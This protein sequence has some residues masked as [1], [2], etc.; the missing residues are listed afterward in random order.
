MAER[1]LPPLS[2]DDLILSDFDGT[3]S[4]I[5]TGM[6]VFD[7]LELEEAWAV[8]RI[9]QAGEID[10]MEC[11]RLQWNM[12]RLNPEEMM[13]LIDK[14]GLDPNFP[15]LLAL[16]AERQAGL[17]ILSDGLD[18]YVDHYLQRWG[19][20]TSADDADVRYHGTICRYANHAEL[21]AEGVQ[22]D[23]PYR[24]ECGRHGNCKKAHL[25][26]LRR[27]YAR[28]IY[29]GDGHSDMCVARFAD[30]IF[31]KH[32]LAEDLSRAGHPYLPFADFAD[33]LKVLE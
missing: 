24:S 2:R 11:L 20:P 3:I 10:S 26:R 17:C 9:W 18:F 13:A 32:A 4:V 29:L 14:F 28:V 7:T 15:R 8:E 25:Q 33:V 1:Q 19:Y 12:V 22:L 30:V 27:D 23:F 21:T 31:A 16:V 6:A 5:D